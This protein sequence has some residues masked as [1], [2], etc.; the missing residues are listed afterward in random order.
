MA[1]CSLAR[2]MK[3]AATFRLY[4]R[5]GGMITAQARCAAG[6]RGRVSSIR[7]IGDSAKQ[8]R[9]SCRTPAH[10]REETR[11]PRHVAAV[12]RQ[13]LNQVE[14]FE[15]RLH[16]DPDDTEC[17]CKPS[18]LRRPQE[19]ESHEAEQ[20][21]AVDRVTDVGVR[22]MLDEGIERGRQGR[23]PTQRTERKNHEHAASS[24]QGPSDDL[25]GDG[26]GKELRRGCANGE[27]QADG[28]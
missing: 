28:P 5:I 21:A 13:A 7:R 4:D 9:G 10:S 26:G 22:P 20:E 16:D 27:G 19:N 1:C 11:H 8:A 12:R 17:S 24:E 14:L 2:P 3:C 18:Y 6:L 23:S 15:A 25:R